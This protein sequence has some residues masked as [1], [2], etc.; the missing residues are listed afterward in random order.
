MKLIKIKFDP[1]EW[2]IYFIPKFLTEIS[3]QKI[4]AW[5]FWTFTFKV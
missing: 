4:Y 5:I 1:Y 3:Y 2:Y